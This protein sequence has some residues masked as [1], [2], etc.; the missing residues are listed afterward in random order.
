M[1]DERLRVRDV[2][3][4]A[5]ADDELVARLLLARRESDGARG[6]LLL[7]LNAAMSEEVDA[8]AVLDF[9]DAARAHDARRVPDT[10]RGGVR[11]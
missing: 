2:G 8:L 7:Q 11:R 10:P 5:D 9:P 4:V 6:G 1:R 3:E